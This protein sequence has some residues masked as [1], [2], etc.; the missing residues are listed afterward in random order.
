MSEESTRALKLALIG[1]GIAHSQSPRIY[2]ELIKVPFS[3]DLLDI[4]QA[5]QL[6]SISQ[7]KLNGYTGINITAPWKSQY[8]NLAIDSAKR[9]GAVNCLNLA[10]NKATATN[11]D[12][13]ALAVLI[14]KYR[15]QYR[16]SEWLILGDGVMAQMMKAMLQ[17]LAEPYSLM[18]RRSGH[19]VSKL[20]LR[21]MS[22]QNKTKI[23][24]NCCRR[25]MVFSGVADASWI[26]W[27]LNYAHQ[28]QEMAAKRAGMRYFDGLSLL[29]TQAEHAVKFWE[30]QA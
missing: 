27:D 2:R 21:A 28:E 22:G 16:P 11:T 20:D 13:T 24:V 8:A 23:V 9:W 6:P 15:A 30:L 26:F 14:P 18:S 1:S 5:G 19:D 29:Q 17:D 3:Y 25:D 4:S 10:N 7:L 12:A